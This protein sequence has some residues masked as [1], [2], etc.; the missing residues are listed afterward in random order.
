MPDHA[1][2]SSR[3]KALRR[4]LV[5]IAEHNRQYFAKKNHSRSEKAQHKQLRERIYQIRAELYSLIE[6][7]AA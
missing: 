4:E 3:L 5:E 2:L 1:Y 7:R 6:K